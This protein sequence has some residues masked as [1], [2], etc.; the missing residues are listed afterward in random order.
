MDLFKLVGSIF[1]D[2]DKAND[3]LA[4]T[5]EKAKKTGITFGEVAGKAAKVGTAIVGA[6]ATAVGGMVALANN[7]AETA[8]T[9]EKGSIRMGISTDYYQQ[10]GYA[11]EQSGVEVSTLE[12]AA[13]K[14]EGTD[15][16]LEDA[17]NEIMSLGTAAERSE[18]A[19]ELFGEGVAYKMAPLL[20]ESRESFDGLL[21]RANDLG[22]VMS[23]DTVKAGVQL[24][25]TMEDLQKSFGAV[26]ANLGGTLMPVVQQFVDALLMF[27][28]FIQQAM[29][30]LAPMLSDL[31]SRLMPPLLELMDS[32]WPVLQEA[33]GVLLPI[34]IELAGELL[35]A[36][37]EILQAILPILPPILAL[38]EEIAPF[39]VD[40]VKL[41]LPLIVKLVEKLMP[42]FVT[43]VESILPILVELLPLIMEV[44]EAICPILDLILDVLGFLLDIFGDLIKNTLPVIINLIQNVLTP[45]LRVVT[46]VISAVGN[47]FRT[48]FEGI[49]SVWQ[50]APA[51]F[52][53]IWDGIKNAF[54]AVGNW[55]KDTFSK[56]WQAVKDVFSKGGKVFDGIKQGIADVFH[57]VVNTII[58]GLNTVIAAPF[59]AINNI[60]DR[61]R[62]VS[63]LKL[64]PFSWLPSVGVPQIP[65]L[66]EGGQGAGTAMVGEEGPEILDLPRGATVIPL[67]RSSISIG[68]EDLN[69]KM[70][71]L[72]DLFLQLIAKRFG[73]YIDKTT[74]VG[75]LAPDMDEAIGQRAIKAGRFAET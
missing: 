52:R 57:K 73:V 24:G 56:A 61:L 75:I 36:I 13:K 28:P 3:S 10:L 49:K 62:G 12:K 26:A 66:A 50:G 54:A 65:Q 16:N 2:T 72:I 48:V 1:V 67:S 29:S 47:A 60:F 9:I 51:F 59:N 32:I 18:K 46:T 63:I 11:A 53:G 41:V 22:I 64:S 35:P 34:V 27:M 42:F 5:D 4:K 23:E 69:D 43:I 38:I 45:I 7:T 14:L 68:I 37:V 44:L 6:S 15:L 20:E 74:L 58:R 31:F 8:D 21:Q 17:M 40:A 19:A 33:L 30:D 39:L 55:F 71:T 25:D 70:D